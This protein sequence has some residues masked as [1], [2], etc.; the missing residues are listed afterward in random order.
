MSGPKPF[1]DPDAIAEAIVE[2]VGR[3]V[4]LAMPLGLGK[5]NHICNALYARAARDPSVHLHIFTAL[6][7]QKPRFKTDLERRFLGPVVERTLGR[8]P[9][10]A[11]VVPGRE[12]S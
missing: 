9:D 3:K 5:A 11:Y 6:T 4:V 2:R 12:A 1:T 7:L 10:L 8:Y